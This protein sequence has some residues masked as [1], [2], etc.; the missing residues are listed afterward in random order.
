MSGVTVSAKM[1]STT[2]TT[3][4]Y[5]DEDGAYYF[6]AMNVGHYEVWAQAD[7]FETARASWV[8]VWRLATARQPALSI[9]KVGPCT[10]APEPSYTTI[11]RTLIAHL[12]AV[13]GA[14]A[15]KP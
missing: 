5:T 1:D 2:I 11:M 8:R 10:T 13:A 6:P 3:S 12:F 14:I 4:V 7:G 9:S 15:F